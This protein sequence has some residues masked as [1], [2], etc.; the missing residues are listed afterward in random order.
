MTSSES[1]L[2]AVEGFFSDVVA[3]HGV[4]E[5]DGFDA[6]VGGVDGFGDVVSAGGYVED[7]T[8]GGF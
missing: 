6:F 2:E 7:A 5:V 1:G 3:V 8:A 4:V